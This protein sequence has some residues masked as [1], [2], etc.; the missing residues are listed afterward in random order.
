[1]GKKKVVC[2]I[3]ARTGSTR[4]PEK[5]LTMIKD[6]P[7][8]VHVLNRLRKSK[9]I[10]QIILA[11]TN[12]P[13]DERLTDLASSQKIDSFAG[14]EH[15]V[16]DRFYQAAKRYQA[17]IVVRCTGDCPV[18]DY[19]VTDMIIDKH[20]KSSNDYTSN[21]VT[22][23]YPRGLDTE[24]INFEVLEQSAGAAKKPY[25][26]E[27]VTPYLYQH[28]EFYSI[29]QVEAEG[30]RRQPDLRLTVDTQDDLNF[31]SK[32]FDFLYEQNPYF[33]ID[34]ILKLLDQEPKLKKMNSHV[35]QKP[36][37]IGGN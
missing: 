3:Q 29:G 22:R 36:L 8:I 25:E 26:R 32:I 24:V 14:S 18:I 4:L 33:L 37:R 15:D 35:K 34:D 11:T 30:I 7:M 19:Q 27:H 12:L 13:E 10:D 17:E 23:T 20:L 5:V 16:L 1:M 6:Q 21:T 9:K 28:P 31:I 2:I